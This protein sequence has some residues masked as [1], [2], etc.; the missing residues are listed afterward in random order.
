MTFPSDLQL[1]FCSCACLFVGFYPPNIGLVPQVMHVSGANLKL[2][3]EMVPSSL[4]DNVTTRV[5]WMISWRIY[6]EVWYRATWAVHE[7]KFLVMG[8]GLV[9]SRNVWYFRNKEWPRNSL[10]GISL[11]KQLIWNINS[12]TIHPL[13]IYYNGFMIFLR[14]SFHDI[15]LLLFFIFF[16]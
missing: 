9:F 3:L 14:E 11:G 13:L 2:Y 1:S 8:L 5:V 15:V 6:E 4:S 10:R 7:I 16:T 12:L